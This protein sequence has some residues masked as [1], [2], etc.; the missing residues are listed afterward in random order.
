MQKLQDKCK[1]LLQYIVDHE[2]LIAL[3]ITVVVIGLGIV[4]GTENNKLIPPNPASSARYTLEPGNH[5]SMLSNWDG[6]IYL[7]IAAHGYTSVIQTNFFPLYALL[8]HVV[9]TVVRSTLNSGLIV[10]WLACFGAV[11]YYLRTIKK[12]YGVKDN[13]EALRAVL[14]FILFPTSV[15]LFSTYT[16]GLFA[17]LALAAIYYTLE[18]RYILSA[19]FALFLTATHANGLFIV[20]LL[21]LMMFEQRAKLYKII[22]VA[23]ASCLGIVSYMTY[24]AIHFHNAFAF[25][26]AQKNHSWVHSSPTY[27]LSSL[28]TR[29]GIFFILI[30]A[31][32]WYWWKKRKSFSIYSLS[33]KGLSG[34]GRYALMAFPV[35]FMLYD[36]FRNKKTG[37]SLALATTAVLWAYFLLQYVAGY[38][39]G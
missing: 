37:Y 12:M 8:A 3:V 6:P 19:L 10:S 31:A 20:L 9:H 26:D 17:F 35:E 11:Y 34:Y 38:S 22:S 27:L 29:D 21:A 13:Q 36:Y 7:S 30:L 4:L 5:L 28:A 16:E 32:A 14:F 23:V 2:V 15:F 18:K 24:L 1:A 39:G 25:V 33:S